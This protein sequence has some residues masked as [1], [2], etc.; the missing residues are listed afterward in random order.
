MEVNPWVLHPCTSQWVLHPC[1]SQWELHLSANTWVVQPCRSQWELHSCTSQWVLHPCSSQWELHPRVLHPV[2]ISGCFSG[3]WVTPNVQLPPPHPT[4]WF[5]PAPRTRRV[6]PRPLTRWFRPPPL[7]TSWIRQP[8][9]SVNLNSLALSSYSQP[10]S[11]ANPGASMGAHRFDVRLLRSMSHPPPCCRRRAGFTPEATHESEL[12]QPRPG[13]ASLASRLGC[14]YPDTCSWVE[15]A[16]CVVHAS[17]TS[18][19][20][21]AV[22]VLKRDTPLT[23]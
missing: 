12:R 18:Q 7:S 17:C 19:C 2:Q 9:R 13:Q 23:V 16:G 22:C 20:C 15:G 14:V 3:H 1:T 11:P 5:H 10:R 21:F 8:A 4:R 6:P